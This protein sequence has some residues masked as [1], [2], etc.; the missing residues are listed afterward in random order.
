MPSDGK[1]WGA[2]ER[3]S[4]LGVVREDGAGCGH[5]PHLGSMVMA[6]A[7]DTELVTPAGTCPVCG[8]GRLRNRNIVCDSLI[9]QQSLVVYVFFVIC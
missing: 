3:A 9:V 2:G 4:C 5:L 6:S 8:S 7:S 1:A